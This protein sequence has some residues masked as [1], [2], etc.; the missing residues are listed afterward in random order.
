M[1]WVMV[2]GIGWDKEPFSFVWC[3]KGHWSGRKSTKWDKAGAHLGELFL[4]GLWFLIEQTSL[5]THHIVQQC[6][7]IMA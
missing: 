7:Q 2:E 3:E 6:A 4:G 5:P 1:N